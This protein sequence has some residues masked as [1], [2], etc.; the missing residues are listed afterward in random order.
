MKPILDFFPFDKPRDI[1]VVALEWLAN[2]PKHIRFMLLESPVGSGKSVIG[3]TYSAWLNQG[4][5]D[6][7]IL[8]PQKILQEQYERSFP[9]EQLA[10]LYGKNNYTCGHKNTTC[11]VGGLVK[12]PCDG[13]PYRWALQRAIRAPNVVLNYK[14]ALLMFGFT[15]VFRRKER[16]KLMIL[17]ECHNVEQQLV[18]FNAVPVSQKRCKYLKVEFPKA[19]PKFD[20]C[21]AFEWIITEIKPRA[22][23]ELRRLFHLVQP[24]KGRSETEK[25]SREDQKLL[26]EHNSLENYVD[27]LEEF[28]YYEK[29]DENS[30]IHKLKQLKNEYVL[31]HNDTRLEFKQVTGAKNFKQILDNMTDKF[32]MMSSTILNKEGF[33]RDL[34]L[35]PNETAF[36][37]LE[38]DFPKENRPVFYMPQM[39]MVRGWDDSKYSKEHKDLIKTIETILNDHKDNSGIVHT[40]SFNNSKWLVNNLHVPHQI[41]HHNPDS[42]EDRESVIREFTTS[43]LPML[44]IS[45]S[46]TEGL[47][48]IDDQARFAIFFKI[49]FGFLGDQWIKRRQEM[50]QEWYQ[51]RAMIDIIQGGGRVVRSNED[52]GH[53][54]ILDESFN[55]LYYKMKKSTPQWW[56][57]ALQYIK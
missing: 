4:Y 32:L 15:D 41:I 38:S 34:G 23:D 19:G 3:I 40:G 31:I 1:Q 10:S 51:R 5:G 44:L 52:W 33:C 25:L 55:F 20:I 54:F 46:I 57:E 8:T 30:L 36:L 29:E 18:Q 9:S 16:R 13:C 50:S 22:H 45:P 42:G 11:D 24:L 49:P 7:Y 2:Q 43:K 27:L 48:L 12:P 39:K 6:A 17:D 35:P 47:D 26:R 28:T 21:S 14:L 53:V 37:S 56:K